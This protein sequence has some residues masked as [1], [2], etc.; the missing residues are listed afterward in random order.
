MNTTEPVTQG[1]YRV[2]FR[3]GDIPGTRAWMMQTSRIVEAPS[4]EAARASVPDSTGADVLTWGPEDDRAAAEAA[5]E[6]RTERTN[7]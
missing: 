5:W 3:L 1:R 4:R 2:Y 7:R 6:E